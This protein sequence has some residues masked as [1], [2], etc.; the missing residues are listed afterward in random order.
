MTAG[1]RSGGQRWIAA[2]PMYD[3][4][5]LRGAHDLLW[6]AVADRLVSY[7][8]TRVPLGLSRSH[9][10]RDLHN[11][12]SLLLGQVCEYPLALSATSTVRAIGTPRYAVPGCS[13]SS[14]S[15][16]VVVRQDDPAERLA[17]L[18]GRSCVVNEVDSNSGMNLLRAAIAPLSGGARFF[19][20][21]MFSG[22]HRNSVVSVARGVADVAAVDCVTFAHL[23]SVCPDDVGKVR[24][25]GFTPSSPS[26][27]L[28]SSAANDRQTLEAVRRALSEAL[29]DPA[30]ASA[31]QRLFL[32]SIDFDPDPGFSAVR[33]LERQSATAGYPVLC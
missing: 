33:R 28:V 5:H 3:F 14:Y 15:S 1:D 27:P 18:R 4:P 8:L 13:G 26:L 16:V 30:V 11:E 31:R 20:A 23:R 7:G 24:V 2:L 6:S 22:S 9:T 17:D 10:H 29:E 21:V 19:E 25:L 12:S 32:E